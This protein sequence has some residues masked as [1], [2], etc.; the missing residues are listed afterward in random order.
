MYKSGLGFSFEHLLDLLCQFIENISED[1]TTR[2]HFEIC[3]L[4]CF[5]HIQPKEIIRLDHL[6]YPRGF[7][8]KL[9]FFQLFQYLT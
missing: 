3:L 5:F 2:T 9:L 6:K 4:N 8:P 1:L 7:E